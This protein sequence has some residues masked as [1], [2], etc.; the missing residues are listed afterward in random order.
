MKIKETHNI[1]S[2]PEFIKAGIN[3]SYTLHNTNIHFYTDDGY[4]LA[5]ENVFRNKYRSIIMS[6][7]LK[8][9]FTD[10]EF[11][12]YKYRPKLL[13]LDLY[14]TTDLWHILIWINDFESIADFNKKTIKIL[15]PEA[16]TILNHIVE[17][18]KI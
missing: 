9:T 7:L 13:S 6:N 12:K 8:L 3:N 14:D 11:N 17:M 16:L 1:A 2:I 5:F 18:E 15:N 10:E 4:N